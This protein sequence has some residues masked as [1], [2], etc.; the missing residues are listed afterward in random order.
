MSNTA[1][2]IAVALPATASFLSITILIVYPFVLRR[3]FSNVV[4]KHVSR[5]V[6]ADQHRHSIQSTSVSVVASSQE[7]RIGGASEVKIAEW[8]I[9]G[10]VCADYFQAIGGMLSYT[11]LYNDIDSPYVAGLCSLQGLLLGCFDLSSALWNTCICLLTV[12]RIFGLQRHLDNRFIL[13]LAISLCFAF[14]VV[15]TLAIYSEAIP[16]A[17][18]FGDAGSNG[19]WVSSKL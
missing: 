7:K 17:A 2:S 16:G 3:G 11:W 6:S 9:F 5:N 1:Y 15:L 14:P 8:A 10:L 4:N 12:G 19:W 18:V 13:A